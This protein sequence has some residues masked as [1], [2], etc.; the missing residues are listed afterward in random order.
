MTCVDPAL[1]APTDRART[2]KDVDLALRAEEHDLLDALLDAAGRDLD[3]YFVFSLERADTPP[4]L[5]GGAH[6]LRVT[7]S[8]AGR[9]F[10]AFVLDVGTHE[11]PFA[12]QDRR[13]QSQRAS[14]PPRHVARP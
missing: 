7:A 6:R 10:E 12:S 2:T 3:D 5:L 8:L 14:M 1:S 11:S 13:C 9:P 4:D